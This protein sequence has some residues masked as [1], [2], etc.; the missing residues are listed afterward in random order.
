MISFSNDPDEFFYNL[1][2]IPK[3]V[4]QI[5]SSYIPSI[6]KMPLNR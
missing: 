5:V 1:N 4:F 2:K 6:A 3:D